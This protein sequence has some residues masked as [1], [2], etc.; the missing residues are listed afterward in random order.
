MKTCKCKNSEVN[1]SVI[2]SSNGPHNFH[3]STRSTKCSAKMY[4]DA[5]LQLSVQHISVPNRKCKNGQ[6][7]QQSHYPDVHKRWML[8]ANGLV[9]NLKTSHTI[10][11]IFQL[12][13]IQ[14]HTADSSMRNRMKN[15]CAKWRQVLKRQIHGDISK[16][17]LSTLMASRLT[18]YIAIQLKVRLPIN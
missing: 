17:P 11:K 2:N 5:V 1:Y 10:F 6:H 7:H 16:Q 13:D 3:S 9:E 8:A 15:K 12:L 14:R 4:Y 18:W